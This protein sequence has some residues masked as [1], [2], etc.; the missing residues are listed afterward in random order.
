[1]CLKRGREHRD[2]F[3]PSLVL[4]GAPPEPG[5]GGFQAQALRAEPRV[6]AQ[7]KE[8][9]HPGKADSSEKCP[10]ASQKEV[11]GSMVLVFSVDSTKQSV[12]T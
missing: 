9:Q 3:F 7:Q 2:C 11:L 10:P 1:M 12:W 8:R 4:A 6:P 5:G